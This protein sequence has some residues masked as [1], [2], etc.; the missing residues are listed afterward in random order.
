[1]YV[2]KTVDVEHPLPQDAFLSLPFGPMTRLCSLGFLLILTQL[3]HVPALRIP[4]KRSVG[5]T[6]A[7]IGGSL[8]TLLS[9]SGDSDLG[10]IGD[11]RVINFI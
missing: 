7:S 11:V 4:F 8:K 1:V 10:S 9:T 6:T 2:I 5:I 3:V